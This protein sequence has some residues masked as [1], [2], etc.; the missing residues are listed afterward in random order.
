[1]ELDQALT[2]KLA[3]RGTPRISKEAQQKRDEERRTAGGLSGTNAFPRDY[4]GVSG[5]LGTAEPPLRLGDM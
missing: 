3:G 5:Q 1:M 2:P 4:I